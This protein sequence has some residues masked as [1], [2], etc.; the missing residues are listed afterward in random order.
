MSF[1]NLIEEWN[2]DH[3]LN[4]ADVRRA[5]GELERGIARRYFG[6]QQLCRRVVQTVLLRGH[7]LLEGPPGEGKTKC[8][9]R[10]SKLTNLRWRRV[11]FRADMM[12]SDI[13]GMRLLTVYQGEPRLDW[14]QGPIY[15]NVLL[16]DEINR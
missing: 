2:E 15:T 3:E 12:P 11:Q 4:L 6:Q 5:V 9:S 13:L 8:V 16:A 7:A 14:V 10:F 1:I